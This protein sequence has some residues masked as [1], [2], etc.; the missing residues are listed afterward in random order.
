MNP[1][2]SIGV[3]LMTYGSPETLDDVPEYMTSVRGGRPP[4]EGLVAEFTRRYRLIG[5]SPLT[6]ITRDQATA[7]QAELTRRHPGGPRFCAGIGMRFAPPH[8]AEGVATLV[9]AGIDR[10]IA[11]VMSPQYSPII[12]GGYVDA[13]I[14]ALQEL[15]RPLPVSIPG[16]WHTQPRFLQAIAQ[17]VQEALAGFPDGVRDEVQVLLTA[18]SMP[19]R[20]V[21][22]EPVYIAQLKQTARRV[23]EL[24]GLPSERWGF[25]YQS[26]GHTPEEWLK[27]DFA[28]VMPLLAAAGQRHVLIAPIQFLA[29][30]LEILYDI[31]VGAREQAEEHGLS[32]ARIASLNTSPLFIAALADVVEMELARPAGE[33]PRTEAPLALRSDDCASL[34]APLASPACGDA[35]APAYRGGVRP[36]HGGTSAAG[37]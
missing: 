25:C 37:A 6:R 3:L 33:A 13:V 12:M 7:L 34:V 29:D 10:L 32:F 35:A 8:V 20:V 30:H 22:N 17:R 16:S 21:A 2:E 27:P 4:E 11:I 26:A 24:V 14:A 23:A 5:G 1:A 15:E 19:R 9:E 28:D 18:H 31:E 36:T